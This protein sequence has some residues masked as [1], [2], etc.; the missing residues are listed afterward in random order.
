[1]DRSKELQEALEASYATLKQVD[2]AMAALKKASRWGWID[3]WKGKRLSSYLKRRKIRQ[4]NRA[5]EAMERSVT[6][7]QSELA[8][9]ALVIPGAVSDRL[10]DNFW[11]IWVD[12]TFIDLSVQS[13]IK[14]GQQELK[15][16]RKRNLGAN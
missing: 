14:R 6:R 11:D 12:N 1:M 16:F 7:L 4:A 10:R 5:I 3:L 9:V 8:D 13:K 2:I 15:V